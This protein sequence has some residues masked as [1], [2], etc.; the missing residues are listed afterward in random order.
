M[1]KSCFLRNVVPRFSVSVFPSAT[2]AALGGTRGGATG[3]DGVRDDCQQRRF[4]TTSSDAK[5]SDVL[6]KKTSA[7]NQQ[8][9]DNPLTETVR[10]ELRMKKLMS[11]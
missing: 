8:H 10:F 9:Q 1:L 4:I 3:A 2:N 5:H 11:R 6:T 7:A